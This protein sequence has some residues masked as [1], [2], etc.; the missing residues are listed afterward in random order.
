MLNYISNASLTAMTGA[1]MRH[2]EIVSSGR[3]PLIVH[4]EPIKQVIINPES[5]L[6]AGYPDT[7]HT[8][9]VTLIPVSGIFPC[10][11]IYPKDAEETQWTELKTTVPA[12]SMRIKVKKDARDFIK[13]GKN[14]LFE[15]DGLFFKEIVEENIQNYYGL[16]FYYFTLKRVD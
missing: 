16:Q 6:Y 13:N 8:Q 7:T 10:I 11:Q 4:K 15:T 5:N 1:L 2:F 3:S 14:E 9:N 12:N